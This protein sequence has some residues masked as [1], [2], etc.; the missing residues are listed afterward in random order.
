M[1]RPRDS[2]HLHKKRSFKVAEFQ[3]PSFYANR[4]TIFLNING[5]TPGRGL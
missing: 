5:T 1:Y 3:L 4:R 2:E